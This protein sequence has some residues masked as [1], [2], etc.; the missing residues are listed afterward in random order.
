[1]S[2]TNLQGVYLQPEDR[3]LM[4]RLRGLKPVGIIG[5]S[6]RIYRAD[7]AWPAP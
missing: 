3:P 1:V 2:V 5:H 4:E 6:I 7:F